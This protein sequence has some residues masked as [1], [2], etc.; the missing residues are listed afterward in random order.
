M[1]IISLALLF[2]SIPCLHAFDWQTATPESEGISSTQLEALK[3]Q[4]A[5]RNTRTL[6]LIRNDK[7]IYEWYAPGLDASKTH[8]TASMAKGLVGGLSVAVGLSDGRISLDDPVS[9]FVPRWKND[10]QKSLITLRHLG[11][12]TSG[13]ADAEDSGI[14]HDKLTGWKGDFWKRLPVPND[15]FSISRDVTPVIFRP[16]ER[17]QYSNPG[18]AMLSYAT[19]AALKGDLRN[20]LRERVMRPIGVPD[21]E[22]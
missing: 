13:L 19:T 12:H 9:K 18:I 22:W 3:D 11:S 1:K 14:A 8:Y 17:K 2:S 20:L 7:I 4:L 10:S 6:L 16:G 5:S 15:P 21:A